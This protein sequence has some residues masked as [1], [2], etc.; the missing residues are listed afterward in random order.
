[1]EDC[2]EKRAADPHDSGQ[3][4]PVSTS[5]SLL[6]MELLDDIGLGTA[7]INPQGLIIQA[8]HTLRSWFNLRDDSLRR[9]CFEVLGAPSQTAP[10]ESCPLAHA[11]RNGA[12]SRIERGACLQRG[13]R[14]FRVLAAPLF[15]VPDRPIASLIL[16]EDITEQVAAEQYLRQQ[17]RLQ[18]I[19]TLAGGV[20]HEV[21]NPINAVMNYAQLLCDHMDSSN[22]LHEYAEEIL[23]ECNRVAFIV[24]SLVT[25][26]QPESVAMDWTSAQDLVQPVLLL[27]IALMRKSG[28]EVRVDLPTGL[29]LVRC[30]SQDI[31]Q[32]IMHLL[33]NAREALNERYL[34]A[35]PEKL[36][37]IRAGVVDI[38]HARW[39]R[40]TV[41][42]RGV[43]IE[44]QLIDRIFEPFFTTKLP[45]KGKGLGLAVSHGI[46][47]EHG[48]RL[49]V[50]SVKGEFTRL[51]ADLPL[52]ADRDN[53]AN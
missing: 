44:P 51:H 5:A 45:D 6:T 27:S 40:I 49:S 41:E 50:E 43:G 37:F 2:S 8:N 53:A 9:P 22:P 15:A 39:L 20:A 17:Q 47:R 33:T 4:T 38:D 13:N 28:I 29:P 12:V 24:R 7:V 26:S 18:S 10:C 34:S 42:D 32:V 25:F 52:P 11:V 30:C 14:S 1:M 46:I 35:H 16:L 3:T 31:Q 36:I 21:N 48:G 23:K 19:E